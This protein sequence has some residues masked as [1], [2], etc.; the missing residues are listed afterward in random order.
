MQR[1]NLAQESVDVLV[2]GHYCRYGLP[3][4]FAVTVAHAATRHRF[5]FH[6]FGHTMKRI[7]ARIYT[8]AELSA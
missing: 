1:P 4:A 7:E 8:A 2:L 5:L 6:C 3:A